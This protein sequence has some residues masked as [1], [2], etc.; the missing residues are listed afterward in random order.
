MARIKNINSYPFK[1]NPDNEDYIIGTD[2]VTGDT[3]NFRLGD[4]FIQT[5]ADGLVPKGGYEG[6]GQELYDAIPTTTSDLTNDGENGT[7]AFATVSQVNGKSLQDVID[8]NKVADRVEFNKDVVSGGKLRGTFVYLAN[9][10]TVDPLDPTKT[11]IYGAQETFD[12]SVSQYL[13][14]INADGSEDIT[15]VTGS[16]FNA[17]PYSGSEVLAAADGTLYVSGFFTDYNGTAANRIISLNPDGTVNTGFVYG[18]GFNSFTTAVQ[19]N[20]AKTAIYVGGIYDQYNGD[21]SPRFA[22]VLTTGAID[23]TFVIGAGFDNTTIDVLVNND[24]SLFVTG[25]FSTYKGVSAA[26]ITK[27]LPNGDRD[28][29]FNSGTGFNTGNDQPNFMF[30]DDNG[31]LI[32]YGYFTSYNGTPANRIIALNEDGTVITT[33]IYDFGSGFDLE[34]YGFYKTYDGKYIVEGSFENYKGVATTGIVSLNADFS[35]NKTFSEYYYSPVAGAQ[36][37]YALFDIADYSQIFNISD[38]LPILQ[39]KLTF[40]EV[41]GKAEYK[42]G[43]L[44]DTTSDELL[45]KRLIEELIQTKAYSGKYTPT[46]TNSSNITE[47]LFSYADYVVVGSIVNVTVGFQVTTTTA[48][49]NNQLGIT[50]PINSSAPLYKSIGQ[51]VLNTGTNYNSSLVQNTA[52]NMVTAYFKTDTTGAHSGVVSF[53]YSLI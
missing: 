5:G 2:S 46:F 37:T 27:L 30:R 42:I 17:F 9:N 1:N 41:T 3:K 12:D 21:S 45:P 26:K 44:G 51:G 4:L 38:G 15:F 29:S 35:I 49:I 22:K 25:Y 28:V 39:K 18:T 7:D 16:G 6:T 20:V 33:G 48:G 43:G 31:V 11:Y 13:S 50:L 40:S 8:V 34:V 14:R 24:D 53:S 36:N 19:F 47:S 52:V 10:G 23:N 32:V